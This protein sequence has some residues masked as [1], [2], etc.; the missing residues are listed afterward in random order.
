MTTP[1]PPRQSVRIERS[2]FDPTTGSTIKRAGIE[3]QTKIYDIDHPRTIETFEVY[4]RIGK[5]YR[6]QSAQTTQAPP[7]VTSVATRNRVSSFPYTLVKSTQSVKYYRLEPNMALSDLER[8]FLTRISDSDV[9]KNATA[10]GAI[11]HATVSVVT[12]P[13]TRNKYLYFAPVNSTLQIADDTVYEYIEGYVNDVYEIDQQMTE[14]FTTTMQDILASQPKKTV[15]PWLR[16]EPTPAP[17]QPPRQTGVFGPRGRIAST[18]E[19]LPSRPITGKGYVLGSIVK[20]TKIEN[21][22]ALRAEARREMQKPRWQ[23]RMNQLIDKY[24]EEGKSREAAQI[25]ATSDLIQ[26]VSKYVSSR[27]VRASQIR[28]YTEGGGTPLQPP[29]EIASDV[30]DLMPAQGA[31]M[32]TRPTESFGEP[33]LTHTA[34]A[35]QQSREETPGIKRAT[36]PATTTRTSVTHSPMRERIESIRRQ[37]VSHVPQAPIPYTM[38]GRDAEG[39]MFDITLD[40][41]QVNQP[42][43]IYRGETGYY[44]TNVQVQGETVP[45]PLGVEDLDEMRRLYFQRTGYNPTHIPDPNVTTVSSTVSSTVPF[46]TSQTAPVGPPSMVIDRPAPV[47]TKPSVHR[48]TSIFEEPTVGF[49][50]VFGQREVTKATPEWTAYRVFEQEKRKQWDLLPE[51][52]KQQI[53]EEY[54]ANRRT[55]GS[56]IQSDAAKARTYWISR[57]WQKV[58]KDREHHA[59]YR[60]EADALNAGQLTREKYRTKKRRRTSTT[61]TPG[62][63]TTP[64]RKRKNI[65]ERLLEY[66]T[67]QVMEEIGREEGELDIPVLIPQPEEPTTQLVFRSEQGEEILE[68]AEAVQEPQPVVTTTETAPP[69]P[70]P[71]G[72]YTVE[73]DLDQIAEATRKSI[74]DANKGIL[75]DLNEFD[76]ALKPTDFTMSK[77]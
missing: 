7:S 33:F 1:T 39:N 8:M 59:A 75:K 70:P 50:Q 66:G 55:V 9:Y 11:Y 25:Q 69:P 28:Q 15:P 3:E 21:P 53:I 19:K 26:E 73:P 12:D 40:V 16:R 44:E 29:R 52:E 41:R 63:T 2:Q 36:P 74:Q 23:E 71:T 14:E 45:Y 61:T 38:Q 35:T 32:T 58:K 37:R 10:E 13:Q 27:E 60:A 77:S 56:P 72:P 47:K 20:P 24:M 22:I 57:E 65:Y 64:K 62:T 34:T 31:S 48:P 4:S 76:K 46:G 18:A 5:S 54:L 17:Q 51:E 42:G 49:P 30:Q 6:I 67:Q 43:T 68:P